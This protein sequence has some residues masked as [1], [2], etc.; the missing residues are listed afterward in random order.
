L[1]VA[2]F[3]LCSVLQRQLQPFA[4]AFSWNR[5]STGLPL[6]YRKK[7]KAGKLIARWWWLLMVV[8]FFFTVVYMLWHSQ[9]QVDAI[10]EKL[11]QPKTS[12]PVN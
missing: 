2:D 3:T 8:L 7:M 1:P 11:S 10:D 4:A 12:S 9:R 5:F 6:S